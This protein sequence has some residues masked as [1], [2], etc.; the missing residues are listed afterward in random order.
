LSITEKWVVSSLS[1]STI[2]TM[3]L[4]RSTLRE[5]RV[6][7][8]PCASPRAYSLEMSRSTGISPK[9]GSPRCRAR[10]RNAR[11]VAS[12]IR[13]RVSAEYLPCDFRSKFSRMFSISII[14]TPPELGGGIE[15]IS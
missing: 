3:S 6:R 11:R 7:S 2:V 1:D 10:S 13:C 4:P 8:M 5:A 14:A 15:M 9:S 12:I